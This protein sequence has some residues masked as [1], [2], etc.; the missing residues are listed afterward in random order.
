MPIGRDTNRS[1]SFFAMPPPLKKSLAESLAMR[2]RYPQDGTVM[3]WFA[4]GT[5]KVFLLAGPGRERIGMTETTRTMVPG[6]S[7]RSREVTRS[8]SRSA[9]AIA[10]GRNR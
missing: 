8:R 7:R 1:T 10:P 6:L 5:S 9:A 2:D 3:L 4:W